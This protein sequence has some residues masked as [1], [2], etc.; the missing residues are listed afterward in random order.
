MW[1]ELWLGLQLVCLLAF[2][3]AWLGLQLVCTM[4]GFMFG[5]GNITLKGGDPKSPRVISFTW[6]LIL[7]TMNA[8]A[9]TLVMVTR[10]WFLVGLGFVVGWQPVGA[11]H[12]FGNSIN[13]TAAHV[14]VMTSMLPC[15]GTM[16]TIH[17]TVASVDDKWVV[18]SGSLFRYKYTSCAVITSS[19]A[20]I[21]DD[22]TMSYL[23]TLTAALMI[24]CQASHAV[25]VQL[26]APDLHFHYWWDCVDKPLD[27]CQ[28]YFL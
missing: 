4:W 27:T 15:E 12:T 22:Q 7:F 6:H 9:T 25:W 17:P 1:L 3:L 20:Y 21:S 26:T 13:P 23:T 19:A 14:V 16:L 28:L 5:R 24:I 18:K 10:Q 11:I 8:V 2:W